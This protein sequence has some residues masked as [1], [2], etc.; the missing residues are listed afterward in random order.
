[1]KRGMRW[2]ILLLAVMMMLPGPP[3]G[4]APT[5]LS[6]FSGGAATVDVEVEPRPSVNSSLGVTL[7]WDADVRSASLAVRG[8][9]LPETRN[10]DHDAASLA[11]GDLLNLTIDS[12]KLR[13]NRSSWSWDQEG[14]SLGSGCEISGGRLDNG[15]RLEHS[16]PSLSA[17]GGGIWKNRMAVEL[18]ETGGTA[19]QNESIDVHLSFSQ[20]VV[21]DPQKDIRVCNA[22]YVEIPSDVRNASFAGGWCTG[23]DVLFV[24]PAIAPY[25]KD[26]YFIYFGNSLAGRPSYGYHVYFAD[27]FSAP[28]LPPHWT[29]TNLDW[30]T[31]SAEGVLRVN[32]TATCTTA[33][34]QGVS[35][36][37]YPELPQDF[38]MQAKINLSGGYS[39]GYRSFLS[40]V[41]DSQNFIDFGI[42]YDSGVPQYVPAK[43]V[44]ITGQG[45]AVSL[46]AS[47]DA[48]C[49]VC[50]LFRIDR[51]AGTFRAYIDGGL[52]GSASATLSSPHIQLSASPRDAGDCLN[53]SFDEVIAHAG[54]SDIEVL[55]PPPVQTP[56][57][58]ENAGFAAACTMISPL[59][60]NS[61][62]LPLGLITIGSDVGPGTSANVSVLGPDNQTI[63]SGLGNA[64][65]VLISPEEYPAIRLCA[66]LATSDPGTTPRLLSWGIGGRWIAGLKDAAFSVNLT[67]SQSSIGLSLS[68]E[69]WTKLASPAL[70]PG[71]ASTFDDMGVARPCVLFSEGLYRMYFAGYDGVHWRVGLAMS[72]DGLSWTRY[73]D[74]PVLVPGGVLDWDSS[75]VNWPFVVYNGTGYQ[76]WYAGSSDG[77]ASWGI[78]YA[79]SR[80]GVH[81]T[82]Q[83]GPVISGGGPGS[84]NSV[85]VSAPRILLQGST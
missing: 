56:G 44:L 45:G 10:E 34:W 23:A 28:S 3:A 9:G 29:V 51:T 72:D 69:R 68:P 74:N 15:L 67:V 55:D 66:T 12:N 18:T 58:E 77:G 76:M 57:G 36:D 37:C 81:W 63:V 46:A 38:S 20:S 14:A 47:S 78:G 80:D 85:G 65:S 27:G 59:I 39:N 35:F 41:Q 22:S 19:R 42:V 52:L 75:H 6:T 7:P 1:M 83:P 17:S 24:A 61:A 82:K 70:S 32:G 48:V 5:V 31:Y 4:A 33:S 49:D 8:E 53:V 64:D 62:R 16:N 79:S 73:P 30:L 60:E 50:H 13:L 21:C 25:S 54:Y 2:P 11:S 84:W 71:I 40:L 26:T 43:Y